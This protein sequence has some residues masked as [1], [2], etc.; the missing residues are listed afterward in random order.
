MRPLRVAAVVAVSALAAPASAFAHS[1]LSQRQNL[2]IPDWLFAWAAA[3]VLVVSF[4]ALAVLWPQPRLEKVSW[5]PLPWGIGR[6]LGSRVVDVA[7]G[8]IGVALLVL[9]IVG[10]Y[11]G[12]NT[13]ADNFAPALILII[14]WVGRSCSATCSAR[15]ARGERSAGPPGRCWAA[16]RRRDARTRR[17]SAAGPPPRSC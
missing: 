11:V 5:R 14:F 4:G 15:S 12:V 17:S 6:A 1:G 13:G 7:C 16:A 8:T 3:A 10:G 9:T 2:P